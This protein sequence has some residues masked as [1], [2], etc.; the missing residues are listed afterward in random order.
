VELTETGGIVNDGL[1]RYVE[2]AWDRFN[3]AML[4]EAEKQRDTLAG[5]LKRAA[6]RMPKDDPLRKTITDYL[7]SIGQL[8]PLRA[9]FP[10][11]AGLT[12]CDMHEDEGR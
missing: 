12:Q 11:A 1:D 4:R 9:D 7:R 5:L 8:S 2:L 6:R 3:G 10:P